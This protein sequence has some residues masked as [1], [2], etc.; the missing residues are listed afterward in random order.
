MVLL[1]DVLP[2][3]L[4]KLLA[5]YAIQAVPYHLRVLTFAVVSTVGMLLVAWNASITATSLEDGVPAP[6]PGPLAIKMAGIV[7]ASISSGGGELSFLS[8]THYYGPMSL[9]AW[10]SGTGAAGLV[11]AGA[12]ALVTTVF[13]WPVRA[14]LLAA[15][16]LPA[17]MLL[18]FFVILP[19]GA[20]RSMVVP[21]PL[22]DDST[23][24]LLPAAGR[25]APT[26]STT[27]YTDDTEA[28]QHLLASPVSVL[29]TPSQP[30]LNMLAANLR[31]SRALFFPYMLPLLLVYVAEY[32]INQGVAPTMLFPLSQTPFQ[33]FRAFYPAY[34]ALYQVGVFVS[35]SSTPFIRIH[36]LYVPSLLQVANLALL[37]AHAAWNF[38]PN[39]WVVFAIVF[40]EGLLGG[41]VYVNTFAEILERVPREDREFSLG[42]TSVSDSGG[43]CIASFAG[44]ALEV[45][46]CGYQ[47]RHGRQFCKQV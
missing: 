9:A 36:S 30:W 13:R 46:L 39:V 19:R 20:L 31:R 32:T 10:G 27:N 24:S 8:L 11:G 42:A 38:L 35:R 37:T 16:C 43:I 23:A 6:D 2:S 4:V 15:S 40:W 44:M 12:Y 7:L 41:V 26:D 34:N 28:S 21:G 18:S 5:P 17:I 29:S 47:V 25:L 3:F 22:G 14:T 45:A 1:A 33:H